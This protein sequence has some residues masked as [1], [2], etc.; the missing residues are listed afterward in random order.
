MTNRFS[1][2]LLCTALVGF[3]VCGCNS[4]SGSG[5]KMENKKMS[6]DK[7]GSDKMGSDKMGDDKMGDGK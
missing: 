6:S 5:G 7:M 1:I 4:D 3:G 2:A